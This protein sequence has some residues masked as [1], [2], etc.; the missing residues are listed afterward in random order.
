MAGPVST[1]DAADTSHASA[2]IRLAVRWLAES[3]H[4]RGGLAGPVYGGVSASDGIRLHQRCIRELSAGL[5]G[6]ELQ[7]E[8]SLQLQIQESGFDLLVSGRC[9]ALIDSEQLLRLYE[10]KSFTGPPD[11]LPPEGEPLHWAQAKLYAWLLLAGREAVRTIEIAVVYISLEGPNLVQHVMTCDR[12]DLS[13]FFLQTCRQYVLFASDILRGEKKRLQSGLA[14]TFPYPD[15]RQGQRKFMR[16]VVGAAR[17]VIPVDISAPTGTGKTMAALYPGIKVLANRLVDHVFYLTNMTSARLVAARAMD[18]LHGAGLF[19]KSIILYAKEKLCLAS[20]LYCDTR[21]CPFALAY[22]D[23]LPDALRQL[24]LSEQIG[25]DE[26]LAC[27]RQH[28]VCPFELSLDMAVYCEVI[29]CDYNYAFDPR[30]RLDRFFNQEGQK[31]LLLVDEAHNLPDRSRSMYSASLEIDLLLQARKAI[32]GLSPALEQD[33]ERVL[34]WLRQLDQ[35]ISADEAGF[36]AVEPSIKPDSVMHAE[37]FRAMRSQ[38]HELLARCGRFSARCHLFLDAHPEFDGRLQLLKGYFSILFF[39]RVA[40]EFFDEAYVTVARR[41]SGS[42]EIELMCLDASAKLAASYLDRHAA[43]FFSATLAPPPYYKRLLQGPRRADSTELLTLGSPFPSE[44]LLVM[45]CSALSTRF[46]QRQTTALPILDLILT[47]VRQKTG[48]YLIFV[49]SHAYLQMIRSLLRNRTDRD[50]FDYLFQV[51][52]MSE[53]M[54]RKYLARFDHFGNRTL[55]AFA[56]IGGIFAEGI[57]LYGEKLAGVVI[58][59]VG[60]P[61][62]CPERE[63]M[64]QY[65]AQALGSGYEFAYLYPGF[66]KVRQAAGRV[67]RS[68]NDRGFVL[69][70]DDRYATP[71]YRSLFPADWQ[72]VLADHPEAVTALLR[73]FWG[74]GHSS[75]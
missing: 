53:P 49:P 48:N 38:P 21:Q 7:S 51:R 34:D 62:I 36:D 59:G 42:I 16:E 69:L 60:L 11:R 13:D 29:I 41:T 54:R 18:D 58:V 63:I 27:A 12:H 44:N 30:V 28:Q 37:Q 35:A 55:L 4:R 25:R 22:Y 32:Q 31:H 39:C 20:E 45:L 26:I 9:D 24:F 65:Y 50:D 3:V 72:P 46:R 68:E 14:L 43:V 74:T 61:Q 47:A 57:D 6:L 56:V 52:E 33:L 10:I 23:H 67:I 15:L 40:D 73:D 2:P 19:M 70:I 17:Q 1:Q 71:V 66:N 5:E 75:G 8:V 64:K